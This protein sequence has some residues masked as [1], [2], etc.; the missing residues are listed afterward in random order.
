MVPGLAPT[1]GSRGVGVWDPGK[2]W[3]RGPKG[4]VRRQFLLLG[5]ACKDEAGKNGFGARSAGERG[6]GNS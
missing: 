6:Q 1:G 2:G 4:G 5:A 3:E